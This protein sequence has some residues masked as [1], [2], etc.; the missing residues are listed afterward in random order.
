MD[1]LAMAEDEDDLENEQRTGCPKFSKA[2][3]LNHE[4][5]LS[6]DYLV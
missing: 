2:P 4:C 6:Q 1:A 5:R 3:L